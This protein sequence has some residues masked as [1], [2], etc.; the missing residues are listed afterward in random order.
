MPRYKRKGRKEGKKKKAFKVTEQFKLWFAPNHSS[1]CIAY[2]LFSNLLNNLNKYIILILIP[3]FK[4]LHFLN[5]KN[6]HFS[7]ILNFCNHFKKNKIFKK[8]QVLSF[9][10]NNSVSLIK[11]VFYAKDDLFVCLGQDSLFIK[12]TKLY[13]VEKYKIQ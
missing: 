8:L 5:P 1:P 2:I 10:Q 3:Y 13:F 9:G 7:K 11:G 6:F 4:K 12:L